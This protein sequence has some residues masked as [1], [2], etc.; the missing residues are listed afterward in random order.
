MGPDGKPVFV[1]KEN[2]NVPQYK[3][4]GE[5]SKMTCPVC[6]GQFDYLLG[7]DTPDG[8]KMGCEKDWK[9]GTPIRTNNYYNKDEEML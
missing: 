8:G 2:P 3:A 7:E 6:G 1:G 5:G 4:S 9:K